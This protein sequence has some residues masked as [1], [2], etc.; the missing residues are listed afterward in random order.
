M[1]AEVMLL[2]DRPPS[3]AVCTP[4]LALCDLTFQGRDRVFAVSELDHA[5]SLHANVVEIEYGDILLGAVNA[6]G[7]R[8]VLGYEQEIPTT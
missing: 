6:G 7:G 5:V 2:D 3:V 8:E 4:D 1:M